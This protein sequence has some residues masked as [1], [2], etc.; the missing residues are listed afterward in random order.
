MNKKD[1]V[2]PLPH[3][4]GRG[5]GPRLGEGRG[6]TLKPLTTMELTSKRPY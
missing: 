3:L 6:S 5:P 2:A 4:T 1:T